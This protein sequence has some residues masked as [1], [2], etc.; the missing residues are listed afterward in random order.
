[1]LYPLKIHRQPQKRLDLFYLTVR[2]VLGL[3][4]IY[5]GVLKLMQVQSFA[6]LI[7]AYGLI[8]DYLLTPVAVILPILEVLAGLGLLADLWGSLTAVTIMLLFF[9]AILGYGIWMGLDIDCGCF[10]PNDPEAIAFL[11]LQTTLYRDV[12]MLSA[13]IYLYWRRRSSVRIQVN[14]SKL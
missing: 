10:G 1:M 2:W 12:A 9:I 11:G 14:P 8:P 3:V 13:A 4:F 5:A 7:G 6:V